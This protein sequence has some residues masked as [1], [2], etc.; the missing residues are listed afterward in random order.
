V[1]VDIPTFG[2]PCADLIQELEDLDPGDF[3]T[4]AAYHR[5]VTAVSAR[6]RACQRRTAR[7]THIVHVIAMGTP[8]NGISVRVARPS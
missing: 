4:P 6:L 5:A 8:S 7:A 2:D 1:L 3:P